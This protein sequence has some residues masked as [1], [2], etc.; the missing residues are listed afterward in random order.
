MGRKQGFGSVCRWTLCYGQEGESF[1]I[2]RER[3]W[4]STFV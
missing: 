4:P 2:I 3:E 1:E